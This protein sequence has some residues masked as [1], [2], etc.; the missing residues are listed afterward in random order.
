MRK[1][2]LIALIG[3]LTMAAAG[4]AAVSAGVLNKKAEGVSAADGDYY[5]YVN[6]KQENTDWA[7]CTHY[8]YVWG[9]TG[10][11][12]TLTGTRGISI[13]GSTS[14]EFIRFTVPSNCKNS[15]GLKYEAKN[16][17]S[18]WADSTNK[19]ISNLNPGTVLDYFSWQ[20]ASIGNYKMYRTEIAVN[21]STMGS[22]KL[23][24]KG[25]TTS[26]T[27]SSTAIN[28]TLQ[29]TIT[30]T[31]N[32]GY[33]IE[34]ISYGGGTWNVTSEDFYP[35]QEQTL[36]VNFKAK[37]YTVTLNDNQGS[38]GQGSVTA[39]YG[40]A[41]PALISLPTKVGY[42]FAG[43][44]DNTSAGTQYYA[45]NGSSVK[46]WDKASSTA[47]L[48]AHWTPSTNTAYTVNH[49]QQKADLS[50]YETIDTDNL[51]GITGGQTAATA[52]SYTGFT[53]KSFAQQT[54]NAD[55]S[56]VVDILYDRNTYTVSLDAGEGSVF[57]TSI[58][59]YYGGTYADLPDASLSGSSFTGWYD[60]D[61]NLV[62]RTDTVS[63]TSGTTLYAHYSSN[64]HS[65]SFSVSP[66]GY[67]S[68]S[69]YSAPF[70]V[71]DETSITVSGDTIT[72]GTTAYKATPTT[73]DPAY[74]YS[75]DHFNG[76]STGTVTSDLAIEAIFRRTDA[77]YTFGYE[78]DGGTRV[79]GTNPGNYAYNYLIELPSDCTKTGCDFK[80]WYKDSSFTQ[81]LENNFN[82]AENT[83]LYAKF[84][85]SKY[86]VNVA[87][88][89]SCTG[90][91]TLSSSQVEN[92][93]YNTSISA[94][95]N[96]LTVGSTQIT[97]TAKTGPEATYAF[98]RWDGIPAS[99]KVTDNLNIKAVFSKTD[100]LCQLT[101][102]FAGG[103]TSDT[104][105]TAN[106]SYVYNT[107][108]TA[109]N[110]ATMSKDGYTFA[111]WDN[112]VASTLTS[113]QTYTAQW[114]RENGY[115]IHVFGNN[116]RYVK[117]SS[118]GATEYV[119]IVDLAKGETFKITT[120]TD[121]S[122]GLW[123]GFEAVKYDTGDGPHVDAR[124]TAQVVDDGTNNHNIKA[125]L[126]GTNTYK[127]YYDTNGTQ[128]YDSG[129]YHIYMPSIVN[130]EFDLNG[131]TGTAPASQ[132]SYSRD[133]VAEPENPTT[134]ESFEFEGWYGEAAC[135]NKWNFKENQLIY[136]SV[137][138]ST[139]VATQKIYA[140][141]TSTASYNI[142]LNNN[143]GTG[144]L[145]SIP[146][147]HVGDEISVTSVPT[148]LNNTFT[149]YYTEGGSQVIKADGSNNTPYQESFGTTLNAGWT[150]D[151]GT[152]LW[153]KG[154]AA[155]DGARKMTLNGET[156]TQYVWSNIA[157]AAN[158]EIR[159]Y[160]DNGNYGNVNS[161]TW[162]HPDYKGEKSGDNC[163]VLV[164]GTYDIYYDTTSGEMHL[165]MPTMPGNG[166]YLAI[167]GDISKSG[168]K[169]MET[170][171]GYTGTEYK[172]E[173]SFI[174]GQAISAYYQDATQATEYYPTL[175]E[176]IK[177]WSYEENIGLICP[178]SGIYSI[179]LISEDQG[180][181]YNKIS[182]FP[183]GEADAVNFA[184]DFDEKMHNVC[185]APEGS[186]SWDYPWDDKIATAWAELKEEFD[187]IKDARAKTF[188]KT[189][190]PDSSNKYVAYFA[191]FY[192]YVYSKY[193]G[194]EHADDIPDFI[195]RFQEGGSG[196]NLYGDANH[197]LISASDVSTS[198][199]IIAT[200]AVVGIAAVGVFF[201]YR[202]RKE[203]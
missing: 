7:S 150:I 26:L 137:D 40:A 111:G 114:V 94:S 47:T 4:L 91:G 149:G 5:V 13:D 68:I 102:D 36:T 105:Y 18:T 119:G 124:S 52:N 145:T 82:L 141:W 67:G 48:Y 77:T 147:V 168:L 8:L 34:S 193:D 125:N 81:K 187:A 202:K 79:G 63:L 155:A 151:P 22:A 183:E 173:G 28:S 171:S 84:E 32:T 130:V 37:T 153:V 116:E 51:T 131:K 157:L 49:K 112:E 70:K 177:E 1:N 64:A 35:W 197:K 146:D 88:D 30:G 41:M 117:M 176:S 17:S 24:K 188:L 167:N 65:I 133:K 66:S 194:S 99:G 76:A 96:V 139:H 159:C 11:S 136:F 190:G 140:N 29:Y 179:Y 50:G 20:N 175:S 75:F 181:T 110:D 93:L 9:G 195:G 166:R 142:T 55:G 14:T 121:G 164:A 61:G 129:D 128:I 44:W 71:D 85:D 16:G 148:K 160:Y 196:Q 3:T 56:T 78:L 23:T 162:S 95:S 156:G 201:I 43:Y 74:V 178:E 92:V 154:D 83:T 39:T 138:S 62:K 189:V 57:P 108:I 107:A 104:E 25:S 46:N 185:K 203:I 127:V 200:V 10:G 126:A 72:I 143:G 98:V 53:A 184:K 170:H 182:I 21:N 15:T 191:S 113:D 134:T 42:D 33:E 19:S 198:T 163:K 158:D 59:V 89:S 152:Y 165:S 86:T 101:W 27:T 100:T 109:P 60:G 73:G 103:S 31:P 135:T 80:G 169:L 69:N 54:I 97:A 118:H 45:A 180:A 12:K 115:Y 174:E 172:Y 38:G 199:W 186:E 106:G 161:I 192:D 6:N 90:W 144:G 2:R 123:S 87:I 122:E 132:V 120:I 58:S